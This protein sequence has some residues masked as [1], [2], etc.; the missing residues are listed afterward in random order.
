MK[1]PTPHK[2]K[3]PPE[4]EGCDT[5][6]P[7]ELEDRIHPSLRESFVPLPPVGTP[8]TD[9]QLKAIFNGDRK[10]LRDLWRL[11]RITQPK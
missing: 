9:E 10:A 1:P 8:L 6:V 5:L 4:A 11:S 7:K 3:I 2:P